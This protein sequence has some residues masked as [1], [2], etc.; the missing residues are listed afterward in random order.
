MGPA[1][2]YKLP[3]NPVLEVPMLHM[4]VATDLSHSLHLQ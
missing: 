3:P 4:P 2:A 1:D